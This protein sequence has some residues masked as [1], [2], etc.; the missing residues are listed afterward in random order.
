MHLRSVIAGAFAVHAV[1]GGL[2]TMPMVVLAEEIPVPHDEQMELAMTPVVPMSPVR[3]KGY[4]AVELRRSS[5]AMTQTSCTEHCI[6]KS[7]GLAVSSIPSPF[8][9]IAPSPALPLLLAWSPTDHDV[10]ISSQAP[11]GTPTIDTIVLR[12]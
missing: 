2:C 4:T 9:P 8:H 11:P 1:V 7:R 3:S 5:V 6:F 12:L 10:S